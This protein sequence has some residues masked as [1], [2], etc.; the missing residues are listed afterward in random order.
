MFVQ[1]RQLSHRLGRGQEILVL[2]LAAQ[3]ETLTATFSHDHEALDA[4]AVLLHR[5]QLLG[6]RFVDEDHAVFGVIDQ[7]R[8]LIGGQPDVQHVQHRAQAR[9]GEVKLQVLIA[10]P[11]KRGHAVAGFHASGLQCPHQAQHAVVE[12]AVG[13]AV[14]AARFAGGDFAVGEQIPGPVQDRGQRQR[15]VHDQ[16][17][18]RRL[19]GRMLVIGGG[20]RAACG[21]A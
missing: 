4:L 19:L 16:A 12:V 14:H 2:G 8:Q 1:F 10:V 3:A 6:Q 15:V 5:R 20:R 13:V 17:V 9:H 7:I 11:G 18:H 21:K